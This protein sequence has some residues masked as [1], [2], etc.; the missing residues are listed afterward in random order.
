MPRTC[1]LRRRRRRAVSKAI[2]M[3][4]T[5]AALKRGIVQTHL[6]RIDLLRRLR[7]R[8]VTQCGEVTPTTQPYRRRETAHL[9]RLRFRLK[10]AQA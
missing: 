4:D 6:L 2:I 7:R 1:F 10:E 9:V 3:Q 8:A 5:V